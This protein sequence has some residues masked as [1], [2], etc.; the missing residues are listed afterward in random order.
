MIRS[1]YPTDYYKNLVGNRSQLN[2]KV[3]ISIEKDIH[4]TFPEHSYFDSDTGIGISSLRNV[5]QCFAMHNTDIGYCQS[6]NFLSGMM[7][8]FMNEEDAFW[9]LVTI[10]EKLLP[11][12]YYTKSMIGIDP[13]PSP[14]PNYKLTITSRYSC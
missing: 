7:L 12:D 3:S 9:L 5:L 2:Q 6:L 13:K 14:N 4:R 1:Q 8:L 10:V 11:K